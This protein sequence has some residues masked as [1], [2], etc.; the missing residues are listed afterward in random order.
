MPSLRPIFFT[1]ALAT[2]FTSAWAET[3]TDVDWNTGLF[4]NCDLPRSYRVDKQQQSVF[5]SEGSEDTKL[6]VNLHPGDV[7]ACSSDRTPRDGAAYWERAELI[8]SGNMPQGMHSLV[9]FQADFAKG[10]T[11]KRE[12]F[13]QIHGWTKQCQ[14]APLIMVQFDWRVLRVKVLKP[15][16]E[17]ADPAS[18]RG[19]LEAVEQEIIPL[20]DLK[21]KKNQ[22]EISFDRSTFPNLVSVT[23]NGLPLVDNEPVHVVDCAVPRVKM[24]IYRPGNINPAVS[25]LILDD[26]QITQDVYAENAGL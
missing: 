14:S 11:G 24:G 7:G 13:F 20:A 18:S 8:Q 12:T 4:A 1:I 17:A 22:F 10:F 6:H 19:R 9:R 5:W 21:G 15:D 25:K 3:F 2:L 23:L 16:A 26:V